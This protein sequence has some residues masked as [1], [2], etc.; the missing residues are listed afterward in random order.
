MVRNYQRKTNRANLDENA[1]ASAIRA[2]VEEKISIRKAANTYNLKPA[3]LQHRL[4]KNRLQIPKQHFFSKYCSK[5]VFTVDQEQKLNEYVVTCSKMHYGLT[6]YQLRSLAYEYAKQLKCKYPSKWDE[7]KVAGQDWI[8]GF[9]KRNV[10]ITLRKPENTSL[11]RSV[12]FNKTSVAE[13]FKNYECILT[14]YSFT[15]DRIINIDETGITTVMTTPKILAERTQKQVG[16]IVSTERGELVTFCGI[17]SA[18]GNTVPPIFIFPRVHYKPHFINGAPEGSLGLATKTGWMNCELYVEALQHIQKHT[19][20]SRENPILLLCDNHESHISIEAVDYCRANGIVYLSFPPHTSHKLQPLDVG[21]FGPFKSKL[22]VA[23]NDWH[24][25]HPGKALTIYEIPSLAKLAYFEAFT[26]KNIT[27]GFMKPGIHPLN[28]LAFSD[29]DFAPCDI[30]ASDVISTDPNV[31]EN[32][33]VST[34]FPVAQPGP[35]TATQSLPEDNPSSFGAVQRL[36][37]RP[38]TPASLILSPESVRPYPKINKIAKQRKG[39]ERGKSR[40][41]TDTP[42]KERLLELHNTK[43]RQMQIKEQRRRAKELR[44][45]RN[46][47]ALADSSNIPKKIA[48]I[49]KIES[50]SSTSCSE[51]FEA[52]DLSSDFSEL[53]NDDSPADLLQPFPENINEGDFLVIKFEKKKSVVHYVGKVLAKHDS[54]EYHIS[55]LRKKP[56]SWTFIF[57]DVKD[58]ASVNFS[59]VCLKLPMPNVTAGTNRTA[60]LCR[61]P[62]TLASYNIQ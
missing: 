9:R 26:G 18:I 36:E 8:S 57:P 38:S 14:K 48:K 58:E 17:V 45:A 24:T 29:E 6:L 53:S 42:E 37:L 20:C 52:M 5:Q 50:D 59:D 13:F 7:T 19:C 21:V 15:P 39:K 60:S 32:P 34:E 49:K 35:S 62:I 47:V 43:Q 46:I 51:E 3:T 28:K 23:F 33:P 30:Y 55:Y 11:A 54:L 2:V 25:G 40:I 56:G 27:S 44:T 1:I 12:G 41:Y 61:F 31:L 22:K 4:E 10:N 16:Q